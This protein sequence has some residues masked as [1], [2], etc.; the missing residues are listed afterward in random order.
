MKIISVLS[1]YFLSFSV[2]HATLE[3]DYVLIDGQKLCPSGRISLKTMGK[4]RNLLFG[5]QLSW[6]LNLE[7]KSE[8]KEVVEDGCTYVT[9]Y[10]KSLDAFKA[11]TVRSKCPSISENAVINE[12]IE[13]KNFKLHYQFD[14]VSGTN[15][16]TKYACS[17]NRSNK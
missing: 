5:S 15:K 11:K 12:E 2:A 4:E 13:L 1:L 3:G 16:K 9:T 10:E 14:Q 6:T 17:Y 8:V 7:D